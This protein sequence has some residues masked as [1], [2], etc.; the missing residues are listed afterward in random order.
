[1]CGKTEISKEWSKIKKI[2]Y[3]KASSEHETYLHSKDKFLNQLKYADT[4][5]V[6][7]L[8]QTGYSVVFDRGW[9]CEFAYS[10][11]F[12]RPTDINTLLTVDAAFAK[13]D[14]KIIFCH[15]SSYQGITDDIDSSIDSDALS[16]IDQ[17]YREFFTI[18]RCKIFTLN[19]DDQNLNRE[20][21][22]IKKAFGK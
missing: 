3:F 7:F 5:M 19:V 16:R 11:A 4:R 9:P 15:R 1:M 13:L 21:S 12:N 8:S 17:M 10:K 22:D 2:P 18:T 6:D 20:I 14:A